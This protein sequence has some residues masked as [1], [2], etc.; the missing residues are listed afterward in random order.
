M[1]FKQ[2][3][4]RRNFLKAGVAAGLF[5]AGEP[6][7]AE[8]PFIKPEEASALREEPQYL[9]DLVNPLQGTD[10]SPV[11]SRGNTFPIVVLPFGMAHWAMQSSHDSP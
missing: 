8:A 5:A 9:A 3:S 6:T 7:F 2:H 11:F 4:S 1:I 10:S